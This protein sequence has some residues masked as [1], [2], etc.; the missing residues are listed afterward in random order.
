MN[1][2]A[3][4]VEN[5]SERL[6]KIM[7]MEQGKP[8][9]KSSSSGNPNECRKFSVECGGRTAYF[10]DKSFLHQLLIN[11]KPE[12]ASRSSRSN[13]TWNFPSNMIIRKISPAIAAGVYG[14]FK[15]RK[16]DTAFSTS[17]N[18]TI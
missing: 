15:T 3:D 18:G 10:R 4:L 14:D 16:S 1:K 6:A 2:M 8:L 12:T 7:T 17:A 13:H 9:E 11:G 5:D